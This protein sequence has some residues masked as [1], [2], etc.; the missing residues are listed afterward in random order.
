MYSYYVGRDSKER[1]SS[2]FIKE[3][4]SFSLSDSLLLEDQGVVFIEGDE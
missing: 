2:F 1:V 4:T 3:Q